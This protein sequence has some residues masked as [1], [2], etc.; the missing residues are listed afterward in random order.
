MS[1]TM[2]D[3]HRFVRSAGVLAAFAICA[4]VARVPIGD[5]FAAQSASFPSRPMFAASALVPTL[6]PVLV[7]PAVP[8]ERP[9]VAMVAKDIDAD[10]DLDVV[11][12]DGTL[13]LF[14]WINDGTGHLTRREGWHPGGIRQE[15][16]SP[17]FASEPLGLDVAVDSLSSFV[18]PAPSFT[19]VLAERS[20]ARSDVSPGAPRSAFL[21]DRPS[22]APPAFVS[23]S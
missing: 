10:G 16:A 5:G 6:P 8:S 11:A 19:S 1:A 3:V 23:L 17:D 2:I 21:A 9:L 13:H 12:N 4:F 14:V 18:Q 22:R 15:P 7:P 20:R